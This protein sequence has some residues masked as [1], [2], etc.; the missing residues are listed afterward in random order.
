MRMSDLGVH[1]LLLPQQSQQQKSVPE[2]EPA[3]CIFTVLFSPSLCSFILLY[4]TGD[5]IRLQL[6]D[7]KLP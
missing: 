3:F 2:T 4:L 1:D 7:L 5:W 6:Q